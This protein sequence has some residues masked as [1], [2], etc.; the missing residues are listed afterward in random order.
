MTVEIPLTRGYVALVDDADAERVLPL[1]WRAI[2]AGQGVYA[3]RAVRTDGG[4][5]RQTVQLMHTLIT[6]WPLTDHRDGDGLNN[7]RTN[8]RPATLAE[9]NRNR[10]A[11]LSASPFKGVSIN[12]GRGR[13]WKAA[14]KYEG[15]RRHLGY[16]GTEAAAAEAYDVAARELFGEFAAV[17]FPRPGERCAVRGAA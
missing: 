15:V 14:I 11:N 10:Q 5:R 17:N 16:F 13:P 1:K 8:L 2:K 6:G 12:R 3:G 4:A 9:N 7:Q